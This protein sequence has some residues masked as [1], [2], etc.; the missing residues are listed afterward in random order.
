MYKGKGGCRAWPWW[1]QA[2]QLS[3][4]KQEGPAFWAL[5]TVI[6]VEGPA[7]EQ[8]G[9]RTH[10]PGEEVQATLLLAGSSWGHLGVRGEPTALWKFLWETWQ[11]SAVC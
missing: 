5:L 10:V 7:L 8:A 9:R 1:G 3:A 11:N 2:C 6:P 4:L